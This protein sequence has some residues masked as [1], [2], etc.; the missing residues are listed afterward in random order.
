MNYISRLSVP[1]G[2]IVSIWSFSQESTS[3]DGHPRL[4]S[5]FPFAVSIHSAHLQV[6][7]VNNGSLSE[8]VKEEEETEVRSSGVL[9]PDSYDQGLKKMY[10]HMIVSDFFHVFGLL[11]AIV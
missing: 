10:R 4:E 7:V 6:A 5:R 1:K 8:Y 2:V 11:C 3:S 9:V